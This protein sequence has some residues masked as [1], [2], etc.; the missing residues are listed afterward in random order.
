MIDPAHVSVELPTLEWLDPEELRIPSYQREGAAVERPIADEWSYCAAQTILV[1]N[2]ERAHWTVDGQRRRRLAL[3]LGITPIAAVVLH[4][5]TLKEEARLFLDVNVQ[6]LAVNPVSRHLCEVIA[7]D[8]RAIDIDRVLARFDLAVSRG[9][10]G[11][12][13]CHPFNAVVQAEKVYDD[14]G[15]DLL[16]RTFAVIGAAWPDELRRPTGALVR[17]V[18][19]FLARDSWGA[20]DS[21]VAA[22]LGARSLGRLFELAAH[23]RELS[24]GKGHGGGSP[25]YMARGIAALVYGARGA[26][27]EPRRREEGRDA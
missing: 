4:G 18:G 16:D 2:R 14:G 20:D 13:G 5:L 1:S 17:G 11:V 12:N 26:A 23:A 19:Y 22:K 25:V 15:T 3:R 27:W 24:G 9:S 21:R 10:S 7:E 8:V 6:R